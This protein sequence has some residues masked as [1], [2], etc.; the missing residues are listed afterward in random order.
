MKEK[1]KGLFAGLMIGVMATGS[2][3]YAA[4]TSKIDVVFEN[5]KYMFDGVEKK[6]AEQGI[7]FKGQLYAPVKF[8]VQSA[9]KDFSYD[10]KNKTVWV[11]KKEGAFKY[12]SD[13]EYARMDGYAVN[14][15]DF[16]QNYER[17]KQKIAGVIY[18]KGV[19]V[20]LYSSSSADKKLSVDYNLNGQY[21]RLTGFIGID[22]FTKNAKTTVRI[23]FIGDDRE[24]AAYDNLKGGDNPAPIDVDLKGVLKLRI[25]FE[26]T[27]T[28]WE[29]VYANLS[30][31][32][33]FQ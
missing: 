20:N 12:L 4:G 13:I 22:D 6:S 21:K 15:L 11:G 27:D 7:I 9:G 18:Q 2:V 32:K 19:S 33:L 14:R 31:A 8:M 25:L 28:T 16:N 10:G 23:S 26:T 3:A 17:E 5:I 29:T 1:F 30:E 24:I